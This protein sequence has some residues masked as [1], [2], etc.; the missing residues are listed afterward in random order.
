MCEMLH[1]IPSPR[2]LHCSRRRMRT[3]VQMRL[4][5]QAGPRDVTAASHVTLSLAHSPGSC[6]IT[7]ET[8]PPMS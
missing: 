3:M 5:L 8:G 7:A 6:S 1:A 2:K 4:L